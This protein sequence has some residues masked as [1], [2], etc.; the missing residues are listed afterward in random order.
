[1]LG[2]N[3]LSTFGVDEETATIFNV[4]LI[5]VGFLNLLGAY[6]LH[7]GNYGLIVTIIFVVAGIGAA[8]TGAFNVG[9]EKHVHAVLAAGGFLGHVAMPFV[10]AGMVSGAMRLVSY[11][12]GTTS[13]AFLLTW[14]VGMVGFTNAFGAIG[15]GGTQLLML[16]PLMLWSMGF[17]GYL[18]A[19]R[20]RP[21]Q[22]SSGSF[23]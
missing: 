8:G 19:S 6:V 3:N 10:L 17:G 4:F 2:S 18:M 7:R 23:G 9:I 16:L 15:K 11:L 13:V 20:K 14:V 5:A 1:M 22:A 12:A 21:A